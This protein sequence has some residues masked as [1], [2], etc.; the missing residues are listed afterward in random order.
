MSKKINKTALISLV[1][2]VLS[3]G[4]AIL[5]IEM[6]ST[7]KKI[8]VIGG[9]TL[10]YLGFILSRIE[11]SFSDNK[12]TLAWAEQ[13]GFDLSEPYN[14][15]KRIMDTRD[16]YM[17]SAWKEDLLK[18]FCRYNG[19]DNENGKQEI[20]EDMQHYLKDIRRETSERVELFNSILIPAE[21]GIVASIYELD[22]EALTGEYKLVAVIMTTIALVWLFAVEINYRNKIIKFIDDFCE[23]LGIPLS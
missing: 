8:L 22:F 4:M 7:L 15:Y 13:L 2:F 1:G 6:D 20:T 16:H 5:D 17:Y 21:F 11:A 9:I 12:K 18:N 10:I 19:K 14:N 3:M 23:V